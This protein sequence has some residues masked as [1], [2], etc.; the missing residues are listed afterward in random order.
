MIELAFPIHEYLTTFATLILNVY[1]L[2]MMQRLKL[3]L[4]CTILGENQ[5]VVRQLKIKLEI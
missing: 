1:F 5:V 3:K 2:D 4:S